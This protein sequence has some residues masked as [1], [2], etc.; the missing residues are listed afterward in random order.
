MREV[1]VPVRGAGPVECCGGHRKRCLF[2]R[3]HAWET[4]YE[5][6]RL[7]RTS[8]TVHCY[9][10]GGVCTADEDAG[11]EGFYVT[12]MDRPHAGGPLAAGARTGR[13]LG[14]YATKADAEYDVPVGRRL[15]GQVNDNAAWY[16]YGVTRYAARPGGTLPAGLLNKLAAETA[17]AS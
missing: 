2:G 3:P 5:N 14:P 15:A 6:A 11:P 17:R 8:D 16:A 1:P 10:C 7:Q 12:V 9:D 4:W 13:L